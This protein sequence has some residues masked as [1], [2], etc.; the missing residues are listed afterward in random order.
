ME[1]DLRLIG[2]NGTER[3]C[4][5]QAIRSGT[6]STTAKMLSGRTNQLL[7]SMGIALVTSGWKT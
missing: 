1:G 7:G 5:R 6:A 4:W 3:R 2:E